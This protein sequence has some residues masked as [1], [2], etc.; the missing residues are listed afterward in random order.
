MSD[1]SLERLLL[2]V[3]E[4]G[5][6]DVTSVS[7]TEAIDRELSALSD[8]NEVGA[9]ELA[10]AIVT[11][12]KLLHLKSSAV[13]PEF[14]AADGPA[15]KRI[16]AREEVLDDKAPLSQEAKALRA[17]EEQ[18]RRAY[19]RLSPAYFEPPTGLEGMTLRWLFNI[20]QDALSRQ[21]KQPVHRKPGEPKPKPVSLEQ[22]LAAIASDLGRYRQLSFRSVMLDCNTR[23]E[24]I[25]AFLAVLEMI[26]SDR[27]TAEQDA[28]GE[29][30][31]VGVET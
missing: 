5:D 28:E 1:G 15:K 12:A 13:L 6:L 16:E 18:A 30:V 24:V 3:E 17:L 9:E 22:K 4:D 31:L 2:S 27:C 10:Q 8:P 26:K 25:V 19:P 29:I 23:G 11:A 21:P 14:T 20:F 7:L